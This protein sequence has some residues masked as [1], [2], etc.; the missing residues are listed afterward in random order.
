[1]KAK[2]KNYFYKSKIPNFRDNI[3]TLLQVHDD[4]LSRYEEFML[5]N[6]INKSNTY[7]LSYWD[8]DNF[9]LDKLCDDQCKAEFCILKKDIFNFHDATGFL[10]K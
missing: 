4:G 7:D 6:Q 3:F 2:L 1:M 8:Y 9:D 10:R 5:L